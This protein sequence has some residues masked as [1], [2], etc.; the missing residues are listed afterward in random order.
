MKV[1]MLHTR[2]C[3]YPSARLVWYF[4]A[5]TTTPIAYWL[6]ALSACNGSAERMR[7][8]TGD[9]SYVITRTC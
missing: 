8:L 4:R 5:N 2:Q 1:C 7:G 3:R 9:M 6:A